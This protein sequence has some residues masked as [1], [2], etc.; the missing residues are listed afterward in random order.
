M[1]EFNT[2]NPLFTAAMIF[3][4]LLVQR[5]GLGFLIMLG[6]ETI[7]GGLQ[8]DD[9]SEH[10][11]LEPPLGQRGKEALD[12]IEPRGGGRRKVER[13]TRMAGQTCADL[14]MLVGG[15]IVGDGMDQFAGWHSG[16]DGVEETDE[17]LVA[18]CCM[19]RPI[20]LPS[21][22]LRAANSVVVPCLM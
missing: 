12:S 15:V 1:V 6:E 13:P 3:F 20:T 5:K 22:T 11:T 16:L 10:A 8:F 7:D 9:G 17:L 19:Q 18:M 14:R 21:S 2:W 4:G